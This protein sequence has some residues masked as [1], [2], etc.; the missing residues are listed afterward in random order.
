MKIFKS[1]EAAFRAGMWIAATMLRDENALVWCRANQVPLRKAQSEGIDSAGGFIVPVELNRAIQDTR[2]AYGVARRCATVLPIASDVAHVPRKLGGNSAYFPGESGSI[3]ESEGPYDSVTLSVK[4]IAALSILSS[5]LEEDSAIDIAELVA[6]ALGWAFAKKE[7]DCCFIGDGTSTY[8]G[9]KGISALAI[10]GNH[11][12]GNVAATSTHKTFLTLDAGDLART[13]ASIQASAL[14]NARWYCSM[15]AVGQTFARLATYLPVMPVDGVPRQHY[16][17][18]PII[19]TQSLPTATTDINGQVMIIF[20]DLRRATILGERR[21]IQMARSAQ[22]YFDSD[23]IAIRG[24]E[25]VDLVTHQLADN[26]NTGSL[27]AL[28]GTT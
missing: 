15:T 23:Q 25:R 20:G 24:T 10:D 19:P 4:K 11:T 16:L 2:E 17:G 21:A 27:A 1:E 5:E 7:D 9:M 26:T 18:F 12:K 14:Q 22:R 13:I 8:G 3:T 6:D 28:V